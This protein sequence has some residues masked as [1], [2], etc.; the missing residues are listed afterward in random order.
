MS[1]YILGYTPDYLVRL[2][3]ILNSQ[4]ENLRTI[5]LLNFVNPEWK[6][7]L[8]F[9]NIEF[10]HF[11]NHTFDSESIYVMGVLRPKSINQILA[12]YKK[13]P[14]VNMDVFKPII[15][16]TCTLHFSVQLGRG[17]IIEPG[18][19]ISNDTQLGDFVHINRMVNIGHHTTIGDRVM[20]NPGVT[21][22]GR[23]E[24]QS[25]VMIG[26]GATI[27]DGVTI[28][29]NTVIGAGSVVTKSIASNKVAWGNPCKVIKENVL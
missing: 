2:Q 3:D 27:V 12:D 25:D 4:Q 24:I 17:V 21:I 22:C 8:D 26:A 9:P 14:H 28:G 13:I 20:I 18:V 7:T 19:I 15:H 5:V 10:Q 16:S 23:V 11:A 29:S 1:V 6:H